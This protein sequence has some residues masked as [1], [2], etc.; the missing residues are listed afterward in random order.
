[1]SALGRTHIIFS[2]VW[3]YFFLTLSV[4]MQARKPV[5][6][7]LSP[8]RFCFLFFFLCFR[9]PFFPPFFFDF[10]FWVSC[11][12][13]IWFFCLMYFVLEIYYTVFIFIALWNYLLLWFVLKA[14]PILSAYVRWSIKTRCARVKENSFFNHPL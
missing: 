1:M 10:I 5:I 13:Q 3:F 12:F 2:A 11:D 7:V 9:L 14:D 4:C 8:F 6:Y